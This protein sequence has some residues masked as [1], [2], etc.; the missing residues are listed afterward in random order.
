MGHSRYILINHKYRSQ[1]GPFNGKSETLNAPI[2]MYARE[3]QN[4][5]VCIYA[6]TLMRS[7]AKD[8]IPIHQNTT[9]YGVIQEIMLSDNYLV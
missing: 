6:Q 9:Y 8:K 1:K 4:S 3:A 2:M 5:G 7:I